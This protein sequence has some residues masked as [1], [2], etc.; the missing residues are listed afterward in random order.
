MVALVV[1]G[2]GMLGIA[3]LYVVTLRSSGSAASRMQAVNLAGDLADRIRANPAGAAHYADLDSA[4][5]NQCID[6]ALPCSPV[7]MA[8]QDLHLWKRQIADSLPGAAAGEVAFTPGTPATYTITVRWDE[9]GEPQPLSYV[10][11]MQL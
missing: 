7:Q 6:A 9:P 5:D 2:V 11:S 10:L 8:Q 1:L 3:S 4:A